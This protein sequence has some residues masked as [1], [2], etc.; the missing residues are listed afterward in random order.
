MTHQLL[1][2]CVKLIPFKNM[3]GEAN[4]SV[5]APYG[6]IT[7]HVFWELNFDFLPNYCYNSSTNRSVMNLFYPDLP[8]PP[9]PPPPPPTRNPI[10]VRGYKPLK[11]V[12][13]VVQ[14]RL[15]KEHKTHWDKTEK[16]HFLCLPCPGKVFAVQQGI[17][18]PRDC[19]GV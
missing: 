14:K 11:L 16:E 6:R 5:S 10:Y 2:K 15:G 8:P 12:C 1:S 4:H 3:L 7:L 18:V 9:P 13:H 17:S 19:P